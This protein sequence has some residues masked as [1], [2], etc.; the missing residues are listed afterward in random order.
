MDERRGADRDER[1]RTESGAALPELSL[2]ADERAEDEDDEKT[3]KAVDDRDGV[4]G[5]HE[6]EVVQKIGIIEQ[7]PH[8]IPYIARSQEEE[9]PVCPAQRVP[10]SGKGV[11][12]SVMRGSGL[13]RE[14][15]AEPP[16]FGALVF[17]R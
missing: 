4:E 12:G 10:I 17:V 13:A 3:D 11:V 14:I 2:T 7:N 15:A 8:R 9:R 16:H 5:A 1:I 6:A